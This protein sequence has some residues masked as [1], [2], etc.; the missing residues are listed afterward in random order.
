MAI[1]LATGCTHRQDPSDK[2]IAF[3]AL[4]T[5]TA[6]A[7]QHCRTQR[8][9]RR[10]DSMILMRSDMRAYKGE[11]PDV[12]RAHC[13][14]LLQGGQQRFE[15]SRTGE[16]T[17]V[18]HDID[19]VGLRLGTFMPLAAAVRPWRAHETPASDGVAPM[20]GRKMAVWT[21]FGNVG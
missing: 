20:V 19:L 18:L 1:L 12:L 14:G 11:L 16:R 8:A 13:T 6:F 10:I 17:M 5:E 4:G 7:P 3:R 21:H 9:F 15:A 2:R